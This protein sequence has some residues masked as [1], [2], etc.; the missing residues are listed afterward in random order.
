MSKYYVGI[1]LHKTVAQVCV[2]DEDGTC[3]AEQRLPLRSEEDGPAFV[4][5]LRQWQEDGRYVVEAL[6]MN[7]WL[8]NACRD[9]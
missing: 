7:R 2:E 1:D 8:V 6:G 3:L 9:A 4:A 5:Y